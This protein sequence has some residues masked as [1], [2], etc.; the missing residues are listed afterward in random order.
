[1]SVIFTHVIWRSPCVYF[2]FEPKRLEWGKT[3]ATI[4]VR[5][6][7][8]PCIM[9]TITLV[10]WYLFLEKYK[11]KVL[12][13]TTYHKIIHRRLKYVSLYFHSHVH[14]K[15][16]LATWMI[17]IIRWLL[18]KNRSWNYKIKINYTPMSSNNYKWLHS[19]RIS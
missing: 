12:N 9:Q 2:V 19:Q 7:L 4:K 8:L 1:M 5:H 10:T 11:V 6:S 16:S 15:T 14:K 13:V 17:C 3:R 18:S